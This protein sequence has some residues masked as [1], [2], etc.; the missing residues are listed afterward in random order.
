[1]MKKKKKKFCR[2]K[3]KK[4]RREGFEAAGCA[5]LT[6]YKARRRADCCT[7]GDSQT[8]CGVWRRD[9]NGH[10]AEGC[11]WSVEGGASDAWLKWRGG[12][13]PS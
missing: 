11:E 6:C 8:L 7:V 4:C 13:F 10:C 2:R 12:L 1:M 9:Y 3:R 5:D